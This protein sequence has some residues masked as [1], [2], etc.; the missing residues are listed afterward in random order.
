MAATYCRAHSSSSSTISNPYSSSKLPF[1][2][3]NFK[4][5]SSSSYHSIRFS[6]SCTLARDAAVKREGKEDSDPAL[7]QRPDSY[8]RFGKF[9]G[10]YVPETLIHALS[11]LE[12]AF[13]SLKD[14]PDFQNELA[15]ILKEYVGRETPLY[16]AE[17]LTEH[18]RRPNGEGPHIYL[19]REDLNHTGAHKINNAIG[20]VLLAKHL[21][22]KRIIAETGAGQHGVATATVCA[23]FGLQC[24][25]Y[26]GAQDMER[27]ALNVFRMRLLGAE[28]RAVHSGTATLKDATS[29]AIRDWV[30][31]VETTHYILGSVAGPHPFPMMVREFHK[32]IGK[33][34]RKQAI[35]KWGGKPDVLVA[36]IGGGSN[37]MGLFDDFVKDKDVRLIGVEAAG[38]GLD[39]GKHAATLTKGQVGVLHGAMSY[40]LQD[41]D[42]QIIEPHSISAGLD[43]PGVGP[44]HSFLKEKGRAEYYSVTDEEAL[45]AFKRLSRLEG[46]IPALETSH[47]LAY[48]EK[49]S[50]TLPNGTKVVLNCSGRGDKD[51]QAAIKYLQV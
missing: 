45:E 47:A 18:Y 9:G 15:G 31:N 32:I 13:N 30:T 38:L 1:K 28:V 33:E 20:Q 37:A 8:G 21:G 2:F 24:I 6:V 17:R 49:L 40:L 7:W 34:T 14:D 44:E 39:S 41:D 10:K 48:L 3:R 19:K 29:E 27:Q 50:P 42:G 36:C 22:K 25:I 35:E 11:E 46:I 16:F 26:M 12:S 23:R 4:P 51:V 43:Y 5:S